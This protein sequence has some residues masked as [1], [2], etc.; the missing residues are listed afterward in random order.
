MVLEPG[1]PTMLILM[2]LMPV[3]MVVTGLDMALTTVL[4]PITLPSATM[5]MA[6]LV[7]MAI[8]H[9]PFLSEITDM[10]LTVLGELP[11]NLVP[12]P[13][14]GLEPMVLP[15]MLE[16]VS[17]T[18]LLTHGLVLSTLPLP[19]VLMTGPPLVSLPST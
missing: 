2:L 19:M 18:P 7:L 17:G 4:P 14:I 9:L 3:P 15:L 11:P 6:T 16:K 12:G 13:A 8:T 1:V 10:A 5:D